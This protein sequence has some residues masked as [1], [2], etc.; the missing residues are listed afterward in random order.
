MNNVVKDSMVPI[1]DYPTVSRDAILMDAV[2][3][4]ENAKNNFEGKEE[5]AHW[6][7][8][9]M[10]NENR[11][12]GKLSQLDVLTALET[13]TDAVKIIDGINK[14]GFS[15]RYI[16]TMRE[17]LHLKNASFERLYADPGIMASEV[18][19]FM[20]NIT[21]SDS[22]DENTSLATAAHHMAARKRLSMLVTKDDNV[23]GVLRMT[24]V[25]TVVINRIRDEHNIKV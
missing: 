4:L 7:V 14:F 12:V 25:F 8:L 23:V 19:Q 5:S 16:T 18:T 15:P 1:S 11:V 21:E 13:H 22:I 6:I 24:D 9:V 17:E 10:D 3:A 20:H 2:F